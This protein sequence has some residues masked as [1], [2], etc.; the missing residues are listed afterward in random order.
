VV[1]PDETGWRVAGHGAW[2]WVFT[3]PQETVY[4]I[5]GGRGYA[6]AAMEGES[7]SVKG[8]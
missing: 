4:S 5:A 1:Y 6:E 8:T 7:C 2:L 3:T